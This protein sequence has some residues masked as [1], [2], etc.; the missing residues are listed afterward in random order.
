MISSA[1]VLLFYELC[2]FYYY[3]FAEFRIFAFIGLAYECYFFAF[4]C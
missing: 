4:D 2:K 1:K 3:F